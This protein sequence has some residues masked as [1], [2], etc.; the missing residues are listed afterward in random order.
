MI[1][2][3]FRLKYLKAKCM[4]HSQK[5]KIIITTGTAFTYQTEGYHF[6]LVYRW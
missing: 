5:M 1:R 2:I 3:R 6:I 4:T